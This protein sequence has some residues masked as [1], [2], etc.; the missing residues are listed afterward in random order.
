MSQNQYMSFVV[1]QNIFLFFV[2]WASC[3]SGMV[4]ISNG[5]GR[6]KVVVLENSLIQIIPFLPTLREILDKLLHPRGPCRRYLKINSKRTNQKKE[7]EKGRALVNCSP[8][9]KVRNDTNA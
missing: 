5:D 9:Q 8:P 7:N 1:P 2:N 3:L 4:I 6:R